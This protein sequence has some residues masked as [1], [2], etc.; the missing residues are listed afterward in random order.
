MNEQRCERCGAGCLSVLTL[1]GDRA[2][3]DPEPVDSGNV[4]LRTTYVRQPQANGHGTRG[5]SLSEE[6]VAVVLSAELLRAATAEWKRFT[7]HAD[8]CAQRERSAPVFHETHADQDRYRGME[9]SRRDY[10]RVV[11]ERREERVRRQEAVDPALLALMLA[12]WEGEF[13]HDEFD[14]ALGRKVRYG[15]EKGSVC[16]RWACQ[17]LAARYDVEVPRKSTACTVIHDMIVLAEQ[18]RARGEVA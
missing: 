9:R 7:L 13:G 16:H 15:P 14:E 10:Q 5:W 2:L 11:A 6:P 17:A 1:G 3:I 4:I 18:R 8:T 12:D